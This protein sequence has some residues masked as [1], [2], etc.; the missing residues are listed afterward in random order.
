[1]LSLLKTVTVGGESELSEKL[2]VKTLF[3]PTVLEELQEELESKI[4]KYKYKKRAPQSNFHQSL[5]R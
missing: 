3:V 5:C 4:V 2:S 1:M